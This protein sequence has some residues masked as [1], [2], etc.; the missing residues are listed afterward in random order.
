TCGDDFVAHRALH[1]PTEQPV[2]IGRGIGGLLG[3]QTRHVGQADR[4][5]YLLATADEREKIEC[6]KIH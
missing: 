1:L 5:A 6:T 2:S 4:A 3:Q